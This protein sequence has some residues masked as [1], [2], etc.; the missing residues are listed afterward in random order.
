MS[1][2]RNDGEKQSLDPRNVRA[3]TPKL[4]EVGA[5]PL[6][7]GS[8]IL[9]VIGLLLPV[10]AASAAGARIAG[11]HSSAQAPASAKPSSLKY[12]VVNGDYLWGIA[13]KLGVKFVDL[14][15]V[16]SF[17][18]DTVIYPG[19]AV[20][21]PEGGALP[22]VATTPSSTATAASGPY[23][24]VAGDALSVIAQQMGVTLPALLTANKLT[25]TSVI[26]PGTTLVVPPGGHLPAPKTPT[27]GAID[28]AATT[29][30][31]A[32]ATRV[33][34]A[35]DAPAQTPAG[36]PTNP[37][38]TTLPAGYTSY[39]VI[40]GDYLVAIA[41]KSGVTLKALL[42][43]N[44]LI[45]TSAILPGRQL[46]VPPATLPIPAATPDPA[47]TTDSAT[48]AD[49]A[50]A[51]S[52]TPGPTA[53]QQSIATVLTFLQAQVGKGYVFN[54][55]GPDTY[56]CSGLVTAAYKQIGIN[57]PHQSLLQSTKG[58]AVD[59]T[60]QP[61]LPGD[62]VFQYSTANPTVISHVGIVIDSTHWIQAAGSGTPVRI[63]PLPSTAKIRAV[64]RIVQP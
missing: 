55:E 24:V 46:I 18:M 5:G 15:S 1:G 6:L 25:I 35:V 58:T 38:S 37:A 16:N 47:S 2:L 14:L 30:P 32:T 51:G 13:M 36:Q 34:D 53:S 11:P 62:L 57:L 43:A 27:V 4:S 49:G 52:A 28:N 54:T 26:H 19:Q 20:V 56:D 10:E 63:G 44:D 60:T 33:T 48:P 31:P 40:A 21:V 64:R 41:A 8:L 23:V 12:V 42:T 17:T 3:R 39:T 7:L 9:A 50:P 61:L 22:A 59:W 45:T 29:G